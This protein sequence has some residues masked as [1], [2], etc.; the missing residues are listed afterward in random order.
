MALSFNGTNIPVSGNVTYNGTGCS[1]VSCN[2]TQVW[3]RAPEWLYNGGNQY[4]EFT[5]GWN[6]QAAYYLGGA[7]GTNYY[8]NQTASTPSFNSTNISVTCTG[9]YLGGG[10]VI[11][12]W[13]IDL[14]SISSLTASINVFDQYELYSYFYIHILDSWPTINADNTS[15]AGTVTKGNQQAT[16]LTLDTSNLNGSYYVLMGFSN[17][18]YRSFT[19]YVYSLKCNF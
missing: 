12:N 10:S 18:N 8:R 14:S 3:K 7:P 4:N 17:N 5:G 19:G 13:K 15:V 16:S 6:A 11:T 2:G 1:T 9:N